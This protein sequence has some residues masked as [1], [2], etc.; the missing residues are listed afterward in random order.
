MMP[1]GCAALGVLSCAGALVTDDETTNDDA[2]VSGQWPAGSRS[3][4]EQVER[5]SAMTRLWITDR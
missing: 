3:W 4:F 1:S 2:W 5:A